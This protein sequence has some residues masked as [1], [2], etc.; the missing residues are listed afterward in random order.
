MGK[1]REP[2]TTDVTAVR[3]LV[4]VYTAVSR[5]MTESSERLATDVTAVRPLICVYAI[6]TPQITELSE[7]LAALITAV[8]PLSSMG[9]TMEP[10]I[11]RIVRGVLAPLALVLAAP[12]DVSV[13]SLHVFVQLILSQTLEVAVDTTEHRATCERRLLTLQSYNSKKMT[14]Q[15]KRV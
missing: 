4:C 2:P 9:D 15:M 12:A 7:R 8:R 13:K 6:V 1:L 3:S 10:H 11:P 14:T 5:Q